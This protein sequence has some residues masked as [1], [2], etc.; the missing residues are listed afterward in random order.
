MGLYFLH[1]YFTIAYVL[2]TLLGFRYFKLGPYTKSK[3]VWFIIIFLIILA[4]F[5]NPLV[6]DKAYKDMY[7]QFG[8]MLPFTW[9]SLHDNFFGI[10]WLYVLFGK[11]TFAFGVTFPYFAAIVAAIVITIKY[12]FFEVNSAYPMLSFIL[13]MIPNYFIS[14]MAHMRQTLATAVVFCSFYAI[15]KRNVWLFLLFIYIAKGFHN[16]SFIFIFAYWIVKIPMN[17][18][19]ILA[20]VI[21]CMIL[22]PFGV[23]EFI[24]F[25]S[26]I[27]PEDI[28]QGYQNYSSILSEDTGIIKFI[29]VMSVFY[30]YFMFTY[31]KEACQKIP[32]YEY[33]RNITVAGICIYFIFRNSPIFSTRLVS[34]YLLF[35]TITLPCI[36]ASVSNIN[37]KRYLYGILTVYSI[38]YYFVFASIQGQRAYSA[39]T[40]SNWLIDGKR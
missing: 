20:V 2:L 11:I 38:F 18:W 35:G 31:D 23:Y 36:V 34:Y 7:N 19:R 37:L 25:M 12:R 14:D 24:P 21:I 5:R 16:S 13:Y 3:F 6:D 40:Y 9:E 33:M 17:K 8:L 26:A 27:A 10:E 32:Y 28:I 1:P 39:E 29:D 4:G 15:K 30:L 22:S